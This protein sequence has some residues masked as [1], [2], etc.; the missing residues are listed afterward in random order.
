MDICKTVG[1][2]IRRLRVAHRLS[3]E[4]LAFRVNIQRGYLSQLERGQRNMTLLVLQEIATA[5]GVRPT[6][7]LK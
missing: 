7:L 6:E 2:N 5:L 1:A 3:Q 4:E